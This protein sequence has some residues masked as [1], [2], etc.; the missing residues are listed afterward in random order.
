MAGI[1]ITRR[2]PGISRRRTP[3]R[4]LFAVF[5]LTGSLLPSACHHQTARP[6]VRRPVPSADNSYLDLEPGWRL[7][8]LIPIVKSERLGFATHCVVQAGDPIIVCSAPNLIGYQVSHYSVAR[9]RSGRVRLHFTSAEVTRNGVTGQEKQPLSLPFP[10]PSGPRY[11]RLVYLVRVSKSDHNMAILSAKS[12]GALDP[13]TA[14]LR[15]D[16][17]V[18]SETA[19]ISCTWVPV[20]VSVRPEPPA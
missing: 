9:A 16:P 1:S 8:I 10:L 2:Q 3:A 17:A 18:C 7:R 15:R 12:L 14:K 4:L 5:A 19:E 6:V 11:I 20:G 13:F